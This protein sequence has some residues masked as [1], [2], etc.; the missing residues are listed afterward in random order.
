MRKERTL[1]IIGLITC[2][3]P[4]LGFPSGWRDALFVIIGISLVYLSYLFYIETKERI[5]RLSKDDSSKVF[6]D[7]VNNK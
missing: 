1:F 2:M 7:N 3:L 4:F 5:T 6:I